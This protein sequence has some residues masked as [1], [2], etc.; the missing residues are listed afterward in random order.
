MA[1][2]KVMDSIGNVLMDLTSD[3]ITPDKVLQGYTFH[4]R[5]GTLQT[6]ILTN[7]PTGPVSKYSE[8][9]M[10]RFIDY[11]GEVVAEY[12]IA[13]ANALQALP[14]PPSH[15]R[16][17]FE[18]WN[19]TLE[20]VQQTTH[21]LCVGAL[22]TTIDNAFYIKF[23]LPI[24]A[25]NAVSTLNY[26]VITAGTFTV[27]WGD[28][29]VNEYTE[30]YSGTNTRM[31]TYTEFKQYVIKIVKGTASIS[32]L[33]S[34][35]YAPISF[36]NASKGYNIL[37]LNIPSWQGT[38]DGQQNFKFY[39]MRN[40]E[41]YSVSYDY[42][43]N[44]SDLFYNCR[45]LNAIILTKH[46]YI[47][48]STSSGWY[49]DKFLYFS[50]PKEIYAPNPN[51]VSVSSAFSNILKLIQASKKSF[52][53]PEKVYVNNVLLTNITG[54]VFA[55][56]AHD[57]E[58]LYVSPYINSRF[59]LYNCKKIK[60]FDFLYRKDFY[61][62][63]NT[64]CLEYEVL[65]NDPSNTTSAV[66]AYGSQQFLMYCGNLKKYI[67][68]SNITQIYK[69]PTDTSNLQELDLS[70]I[71]S[72]PTLLN[73]TTPSYITFKIKVMPGTLSLYAAATNWSTLYAAGLIEEATE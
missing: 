71:E 58:Y 64:P 19:Y 44:N 57:I 53:F 35:S 45:M 70:A 48:I 33:S 18:C 72:P 21:S 66:N 50:L 4:D 52:I 62:F 38:S 36:Y 24:T 41:K 30:S 49:F 15:E 6:G 69:I 17:V 61:Q 1:I 27:D 31:H 68:G 9:N 63:Y 40:L 34:S 55:Y 67:L 2:N 56:E 29:T 11:D 28:G 25:L 26:K 39:N 20:E 32:M 59:T 22:Y 8:D 65:E 12:S 73:S 16:I 13:E 7:I 23:M 14:T 43:F 54:Q 51:N 37:E 60:K 46:F 47:V 3:T 10:V 5:S 42:W